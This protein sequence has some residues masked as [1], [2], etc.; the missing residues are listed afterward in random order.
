MRRNFCPMLVAI[1]LSF[2]IGSAMADVPAPQPAP[3]LVTLNVPNAT[4]KE[5]FDLDNPRSSFNITIKNISSK[6]QII[7][8]DWCSWGY[9]TVSLSVVAINGKTLSKPL[10]ITKG[11]RS[12]AA[13]FPDPQTLK[14]GEEAVRQ[15][16]VSDL[17][18][19]YYVLPNQKDK[20]LVSGPI[21]PRLSGSNNS[22]FE[23][24]KAVAVFDTLN[25]GNRVVGNAHYGVWSGQ[26]VS[27]P[28][29]FRTGL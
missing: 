16:F 22:R 27:A 24:I 23:T 25:S 28:V 8:Q 2:C 14:P 18:P 15:I 26:I 21:L 13:N 20:R 29:T 6:P 12:W 9:Y 1:L 19:I 7:W 17:E 3:F 11:G 4:G 5:Y 10:G